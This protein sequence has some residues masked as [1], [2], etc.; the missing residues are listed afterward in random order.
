MNELKQKLDEVANNF[1]IT[2]AFDVYE[3]GRVVFR[4]AYTDGR[5]LPLTPDGAQ[6]ICFST[7]PNFDFGEGMAVVERTA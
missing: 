6:R 4:G 5:H 7:K 1:N 2:T 3:D